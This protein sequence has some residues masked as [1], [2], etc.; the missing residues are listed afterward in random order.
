MALT[1]EQIDNLSF[2]YATEYDTDAAHDDL[3]KVFKEY[4]NDWKTEYYVYRTICKNVGF[5]ISN[6]K[7]F[8][9]NINK[10]RHSKLYTDLFRHFHIKILWKK[11]SRK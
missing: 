4:G 10:T 11:I 3:I 8:K 7:Y 1:K 5:V 6:T 2:W 9:R